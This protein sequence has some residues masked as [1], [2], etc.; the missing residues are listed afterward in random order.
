[1]HN[2]PQSL[3]PA[4][5][6]T[7]RPTRARCWWRP[8]VVL[9]SG[10]ASALALA[11]VNEPVTLQANRDYLVGSAVV[12]SV[13]HLGQDNR[14]LRLDPVWAFQIGRFRLVSGTAASLLS[15]GRAP[16]DAG[17]S[18]V[19]ASTGDWRLS[20]SLRIRDGRDADNGDPLLR[21]VPGTHTTLLGRLN[22]SRPLG[23]RWT[24][25]VTATQDLL[26]KGA[27]LNLDFGLGY[28][29]PVSAS[30]YWDASAGVGWGNATARRTNYGISPEAAAA[31]G[32]AAY[33]P[34]A[35][36]DS[37]FLGWNLT[38]ALNEHW[39]LWGGVEVSQLQGAAGRSPLV[40]RPLTTS[41]TVGLAWRDRR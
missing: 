29:H 6:F 13:P 36:W 35:G 33:V 20:T 31:S 14:S 10:S 32:R 24:G 18:T 37:V 34:G 30:T 39:V 12:S 15:V 11:Q 2:T 1:M 28:H 9:L 41:V 7:G 25:S 26:G 4:Q 38:S 5:W 17:L 16:V 22:A 19:L 3:T 23:R 27:G 8:W 40:G 21:G